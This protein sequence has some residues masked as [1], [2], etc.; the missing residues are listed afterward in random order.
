MYVDENDGFEIAFSRKVL[1]NGNR[2][3]KH[4]YLFIIRNSLEYSDI[5]GPH[6][7]EYEDDCLL[8]YCAVQSGRNLPTFGGD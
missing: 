3:A 6:G 2:L 1:S 7:S 8:G 4:L 5:S